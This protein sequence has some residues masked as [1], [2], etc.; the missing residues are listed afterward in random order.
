MNDEQSRSTTAVV[1]V[2]AGRGSR[3]GGD[4]GPKQ[5]R[6]LGGQTVLAR[7]VS[8]FA[9]HPTVDKIVVV[10][11][12]DDHALYADSSIEF[13]KTTP[14]VVGGATRQKSVL[15][16]LRALKNFNPDNV[17]IHDAARPFVSSATVGKIVDGLKHHPAVLPSMPVTDTI[18]RADR[19]DHVLETVPREEMFAAQTP[20]GFHFA[21]VL[22]AHER[23]AD[24]SPTE[25]TD[26]SAVAE[27]AGIPVSLVEG[28][29][30]N[31]KITTMEDLE[32]A[33]MRLKAGTRALPDIR[34]GHGYDTHQLVEGNS[35]WLCGVNL[36][37][38]HSLSGHS[39]FTPR[40]EAGIVA[41]LPPGRETTGGAG[42]GCGRAGFLPHNR[43]AEQADARR[44]ASDRPGGPA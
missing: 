1:I 11:H 26:D 3:V 33:R 15:A 39:D 34:V 32:A 7:T 41:A 36:P 30:E 21:R 19:S 35:I 29:S 18:K 5:Y 13:D 16:G 42:R 25:F 43:D 12:A 4:G 37:H 8:A 9:E 44:Y 31:R 2:A 20:Q 24:E 27:W 22:Q 38:T 28:N 17:L 23:A 6:D 40:R 14:P 10:I